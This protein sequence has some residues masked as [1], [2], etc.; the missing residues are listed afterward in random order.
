MKI[1]LIVGA[2][3]LTIGAQAAFAD[4]MFH[5]FE[6][7]SLGDL[8]ANGAYTGGDSN[9]HR[10]SGQWWQPGNGVAQGSVVNT[11]AFN[12]TN[13]L[14]VSNNGSGNDGV[15]H[16][17]KTPTLTQW[18]GETGAPVNANVNGFTF[19]YWF[20]T[21]STTAVNDFAFT[22]NAW[23]GDRYTWTAFQSDS[24]GNL[25]FSAWAPIVDGNEADTDLATNLTWGA[26][27]RVQGNVTFANGVNGNGTP[28]D[29]FS[30]Q[31]FNAANAQIGSAVTSTW[32]RAYRE[33][34]FYDSNAFA[35]DGLGFNV[36]FNGTGPS[37]YLD[38][39]SYAAVP[40]P[41]TIAAVGL[42]VAALIRRRRKS[43]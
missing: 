30:L 33:D 14:Q 43:A 4:S 32:E 26:W 20:R 9:A 29:V 39:I 2:G 23:G 37:G 11:V 17:L 42:G 41:G 19:S 1:K 3:M 13:S 21:A 5:S 25:K 27:Y 7:S 10:A 22:S 16:G 18:A 12:G 36:R 28:N 6:T 34:W 38:D 31:L 40:E 8:A 35:V 15:V 24:N